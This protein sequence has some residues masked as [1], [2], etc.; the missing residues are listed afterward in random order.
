MSVRITLNDC[1]CSSIELLTGCKNV[2]NDSR[3]EAPCFLDMLP[4]RQGA[5]QHATC[6]TQRNVHRARRLPPSAPSCPDWQ[7]P[8]SQW[9]HTAWCP[10]L[11]GDVYW[12]AARPRDCA[13]CAA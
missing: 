5:P 12:R 1:Y 13:S 4:R 9:P 11:S 2:V 3:A 7:L 6:M 10:L 8:N